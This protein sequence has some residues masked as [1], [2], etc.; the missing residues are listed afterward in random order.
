MGSSS[1]AT[2]FAPS[3]VVPRSTPGRHRALPRTPSRGLP[4]GPGALVLASGVAAALTVPAAAPALATDRPLPVAT[5]DARTAGPQAHGSDAAPGAPTPDLPAPM[6]TSPATSSDA[7]SPASSAGPT[8]ASSGS[9]AVT[10]PAPSSAP[11]PASSPVAGMD[12]DRLAAAVVEALA[13]QGAQAQAGDTLVVVIQLPEA[14]AGS[15]SPAVAVSPPS[16]ATR[17]ASPPPVV[18]GT[19]VPGPP[20][21]PVPATPASGDEGTPSTPAPTAPGET[22]EDGDGDAPPTPPQRSAPGSAQTGAEQPSVV[23]S[24]G[25]A[26]KPSE[27]PSAKPS[28]EP[29]AKPAVKPSTT[30]A[31]GASPSRTERRRETPRRA[32]PSTPARAVD[33]ATATAAGLSGIR[34]RWGGTSTKGFDCSGFTQH[35]YG[36]VGVE[37]PR[38]AAAQQRF[39]KKT[40]DPRPGDLVFFG[41]PAHHVGIYAGKGKMYDA[42]RTGKH[43]GLHRIWS[44]NA[45]YGRVR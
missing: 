29:P 19:S 24:E 35:V 4:R 10:P 15:P 39:A 41:R 1:S 30:K 42:P 18:P 37:L 11:A 34:Y 17:P 43:T 23:P 44:P 12:R 13:R 45:T 20:V 6:P 3:A 38:T 22:A 40:N 9:P 8:V 26:G 28:A 33:R 32:N 21:S 27:T 5:D 31:P 36:R 2:A 16:I 25:P 14:T 7:A